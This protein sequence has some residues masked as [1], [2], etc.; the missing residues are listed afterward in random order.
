MQYRFDIMPGYY[1]STNYS[2]LEMV[3]IE[4]PPHLHLYGQ[5]EEITDLTR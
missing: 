3:I 5:T 4:E 1:Y 2:A